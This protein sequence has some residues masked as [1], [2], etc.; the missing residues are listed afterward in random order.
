MP[1]NSEPPL[2]A[3][4]RPM[5]ARLPQMPAEARMVQA[6]ANASMVAKPAL[7][8]A[9]AM[10]GGERSDSPWLRATMLTPSVTGFMTTTRIGAIDPRWQQAL[11]HKPAQSV[12]M[13]FSADPA[14]GMVADRF[15]G[16]AVVFLA[17]ATF[18]PQTTASLR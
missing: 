16:S 9:L 2:A 10:G 4:A 15:T 14:L 7:A 1:P 13:T 12:M 18:A 11:L 5:G 17:T 8:P 6:S 3:R